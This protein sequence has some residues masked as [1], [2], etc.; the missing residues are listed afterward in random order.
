MEKQDQ[1]QPHSNDC[2]ELFFL[3]KF[4]RYRVQ[5]GVNVASNK[6]PKRSRWLSGGMTLVEV[7]KIIDQIHLNVEPR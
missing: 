3:R 2:V 6:M 4:D 7:V 5:F 1:F